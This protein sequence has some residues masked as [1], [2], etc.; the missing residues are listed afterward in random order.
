M[1]DLHDE[2]YGPTDD[3][4]NV[5]NHVALQVPSNKSTLV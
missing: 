2:L 1:F 3:Y 5:N 4:V